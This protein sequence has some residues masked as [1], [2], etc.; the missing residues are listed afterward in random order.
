[1]ED[2]FAHTG[3]YTLVGTQWSSFVLEVGFVCPALCI[4]LPCSHEMCPLL[5]CVAEACDLSL[6]VMS[7][8]SLCEEGEKSKL[9]V[10]G[11][12]LVA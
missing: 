1:M 9:V 6:C 4:F 5:N 8:L 11:F 7:V 3:K 10:L 2:L 12:V